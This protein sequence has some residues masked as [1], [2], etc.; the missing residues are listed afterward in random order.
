MKET[1]STRLSVCRIHG[2]DES[3]ALTIWSRRNGS[4]G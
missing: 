4:D 1:P 3:Q 2:R